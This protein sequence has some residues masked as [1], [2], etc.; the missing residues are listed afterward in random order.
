MRA[1]VCVC[2]H[3]HMYQLLLEGPLSKLNV[4][5]FYWMTPKW[6]HWHFI[7]SKWHSP[8]DSLRM[9]PWWAVLWCWIDL[10]KV[11]SFL[12]LCF[13]VFSGFQRSNNHKC[14]RFSNHKMGFSLSSISFLSSQIYFSKWV[15]KIIS[16]LIH[17]TVYLGVCNM[18]HVLIC[19]HMNS[20]TLSHSYPPSTI[21][22]STW[23]I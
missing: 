12:G 18:W 21:C 22:V 5:P 6:H 17:K 11:F 3:I 1:C 13:L 9:A 10:C 7:L 2:I 14:Q 23:V 19:A 8:K 16:E 20:Y 15:R 4:I